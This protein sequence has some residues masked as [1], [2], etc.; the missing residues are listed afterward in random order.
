MTNIAF[1]PNPILRSKDGMLFR[2]TAT[3][4]NLSCGGIQARKSGIDISTPEDHPMD[5]NDKMKVIAA[6]QNQSSHKSFVIDS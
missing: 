2:I 5:G 3:H 4:D 1:G 6:D